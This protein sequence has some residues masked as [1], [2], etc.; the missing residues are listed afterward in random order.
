[1]SEV[2]KGFWHGTHR[3]TAPATTLDRVRPLAAEFGITRTANVTGLDRI[4]LPVVMVCRPNSRSISVQ[5]GKGLSLEAAKASGVME[6]V[7]TFHAEHILLPLKHASR[8]DLAA[9]HPLIDVD[10]LPGTGRFHDDLPLLWI[11]GRDLRSRQSVWLPYEL[12]HADFTLPQPAGSGCFPATTN[13]LA[14]GNVPLE[15]LVHGLCE[16]IERDATTLFHACREAERARRRLD[17]ASVDDPTCRSVLD[18]LDMSGFDLAVWDVTS[19]LGV[20]CFEALLLDR[21]YADGHLGHG[22][23]CHPVREVALLRALTEAVQVRMTY[24]VGVRDDLPTAQFSRIGR[25]RKR[26]H[27]RLAAEP[28]GAPQTFAAIPSFEGASFDQDLSWLLARLTAVGLDRVVT[29]DLTRPEFG[30]PV[31]RVIVPGLEPPD[32]GPDYRP[33]PRALARRRAGR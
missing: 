14:S 8:R 9:A 29:V 31:V 4:G 30:I 12:V 2:A 21:Q 19:D 6:A 11:E 3:A 13:G 24:I 28:D 10:G 7:E 17:L 15:A 33:G 16:V 26:L 18:R 32:D 20:P 25:Q 27:A 22:A 23:G 1:M 5:Q